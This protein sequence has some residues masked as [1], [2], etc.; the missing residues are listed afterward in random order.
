MA[1]H[2]SSKISQLQDIL[3]RQASTKN[4]L[5]KELVTLTIE[6]QE[7]CNYLGKLKIACIEN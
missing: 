3:A 1:E 6:T 4:E 2:Y 7:Q 5:T